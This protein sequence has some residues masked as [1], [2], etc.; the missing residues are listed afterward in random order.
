M[1]AAEGFFSS[2]EFVL[3]RQNEDENRGFLWRSSFK[4]LF[5]LFYVFIEKVVFSTFFYGVKKIDKDKS[6]VAT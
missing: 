6:G 1:N 5:S 3:E 4:L 2:V